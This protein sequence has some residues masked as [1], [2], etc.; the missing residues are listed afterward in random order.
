MYLRDFRPHIPSITI[1]ELSDDFIGIVYIGQY[2]CYLSH[3][4]FLDKAKCIVVMKL[5]ELKTNNI[6]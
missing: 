2:V 1:F 5:S 6:K 4:W 3:D